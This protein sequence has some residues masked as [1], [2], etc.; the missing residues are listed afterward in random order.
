MGLPVV[1]MKT[2]SRDLGDTVNTFTTRLT[3][4]FYNKVHY[5]LIAISTVLNNGYRV[6][7]V[8][9][10]VVLLKNPFPYLYSQ[11]EVD[12]IAQKDDYL[13]SGF[14][15]IRPT[16]KSVHAFQSSLKY[17]SNEGDNAIIIRVVVSEKL[18]L[19]LLPLSLFS[20]GNQFFYTHQYYWDLKNSPMYTFH[21]N[22]VRGGVGKTLRMREMKMY[23][24][25][26]NG[27]YSNPNARYIS[28]ETIRPGASAYTQTTDQLVSNQLRLM[29]YVANQLNRSLILPP[30]PC[31]KNGVPYCN[32]CYFHF[33]YCFEDILKNA[34]L[35]Y[36][37]S[38]C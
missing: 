37:E 29:I 5:K 34:T 20:S 9:S 27:E 3:K 22:Y 25:D 32:L 15:Y 13:C 21:N 26:N 31:K 7:Y 8:D 1:L 38:V 33:R 14:M 10:D 19:T 4:S 6:L 30:I 35:P 17:P 18:S 2:D 23:Y 24:L 36:K 12:M 28:F 11:P 16:P